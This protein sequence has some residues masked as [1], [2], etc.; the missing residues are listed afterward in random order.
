MRD[1]PSSPFVF[2]LEQYLTYLHHLVSQRSIVWEEQCPN[3]Q[4]SSQSSKPQLHHHRRKAS[5]LLVVLVVEFIICWTPLYLYHTIGTF[6]SSIYRSLPSWMLDLFL[7]LSFLSAS[8]NPM[9]YYFM[10]HRY[11]K[12]LSLTLRRFCCKR[13]EP[14]SIHKTLKQ[15]LVVVQFIVIDGQKKCLLTRTIKSNPT[16]EEKT[17]LRR[18]EKKAYAL[19]AEATI[20]SRSPYSKLRSR[21]SSRCS[22][23]KKTANM[24]EDGICY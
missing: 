9:T 23:F 2:L 7:L 3:R 4:T 22:A 6:D 14:K 17:P 24:K 18:S 1:R 21:S 15:N 20:T 19:I 11:R 12:L 16:W 13:S 5:V 10:S 8:C